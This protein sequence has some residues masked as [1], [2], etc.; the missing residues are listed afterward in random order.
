MSAGQTQQ[1]PVAFRTSGGEPIRTPLD[2]LLSAKLSRY[3]E[4]LLPGLPDAAMIPTVSDEDLL[5]L[6]VSK[7]FHRLRFLREARQMV[8]EPEP[9][10][11]EPEPEQAVE[12]TRAASSVQL[13]FGK[14]EELKARRRRSLRRLVL[15]PASSTWA[16]SQTAKMAEPEPEPEPELLEPQ[17]SAPAVG[18]QPTDTNHGRNLAGVQCGT[19]FPDAAEFVKHGISVQGL[20][21]DGALLGLLSRE[22]HNERYLPRAYQASHRPRRLA[23]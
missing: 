5:R 8:P 11:Q 23:G 10:E 15:P 2:F 9:P 17:D 19:S 1:G 18:R 3:S 20:L 6:G 4:Q 12:V 22:H 13:I 7:P 16:A 14:K 21:W